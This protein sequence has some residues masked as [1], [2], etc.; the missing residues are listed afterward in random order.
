[1]LARPSSE[2]AASHSDAVAGLFAPLAAQL[3][4]LVWRLATAG[5]GSD[6]GGGESGGG[7]GG[8][9]TMHRVCSG[10]VHWTAVSL[11][12][13]EQ[14]AAAPAALALQLLPPQRGWP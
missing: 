13:V 7:G 12:S 1:M 14:H 3:S 11:M 2:A 5:V 6:G 9:D 4:P 8:W 10:L